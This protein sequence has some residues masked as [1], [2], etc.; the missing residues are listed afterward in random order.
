MRFKK[1][2]KMT[3]RKS[4]KNFSKGNRVNYRNV[5]AHPM[6]GGIRM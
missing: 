3:R 5:V 2:F 1:R 6:R 4:R